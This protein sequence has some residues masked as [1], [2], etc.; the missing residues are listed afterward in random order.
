MGGGGGGRG[1]GYIPPISNNLYK[2]V[3]QA[4]QI[5]QKRLDSDVNNFLRDILAKFNDRDI[6]TTKNR[7]ERI[8]QKL[9]GV[10]EIDQFLFG[11][12][13]AK[14]TYVNGLS[15]IDALV[16]LERDDLKGRSPSA[17]LNSFYKTLNDR[18]TRE[19]VERVKKGK[20]AVTVFYRDGL[21]I[22]ILPA[23][24]SH[25]KVLIPNAD[26]TSWNETN[27]GRFRCELTKANEHLNYSLVPA[28]KLMKSVNDDLP[29]Q[30]QLTGYHMEAL[31]LDAAKS[32]RGPKTPKAILLHILDH[33]AGRVLK[34][35]ADATGQSRIVDSYLGG[36]N[37]L[38]RKNISYALESTRRRLESASSLTQW[39]SVF[40][41]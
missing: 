12:S 5:E 34:P 23:L 31:A 40:S 17:V 1:S 32:Y 20:L 39:R 22:Q 8:G 35:I 29:K 11:G 9:E 13:V 16:V 36:E 19:D 25:S 3:E 26:G 6:D 14:H 41:E 2:K 21:E 24:R 10:V 38:G 27:P 15:D 30:K 37:S 33:S 7:L 28:I 18:L 4:R